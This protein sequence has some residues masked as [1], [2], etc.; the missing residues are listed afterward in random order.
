MKIISLLALLISFTPTS[1]A[2]KQTFDLITFTPPKGWTIEEKQNVIVY[3]NVD[4]KNKTWCQIGVYKS[5]ASKGNIEDDLQS[6]WNEMAVKQ[7][8]IADT[9]QATETQEAEGWKI[10]TGSGKFTFNNQPAAVLLTTFSGYDRCTS[11]I[12]TTNSQSYLETIEKFVGSI[13]LK[14]PEKTGN[15]NILTVQQTSTSNPGFAFSTTNFDDG[16]T[17]T[18]QEDWVEVTKGSMKVLLHYPKEGTIFPA[19]PAPLTNAAWNI[20]V[21]PRY[22]NLK[23]YKT[24]YV[25]DYKRPYFGMGYATEN[26][27]GNSVFIVLFRRGGGWIEVVTT[28]NNSFTREFGFNPETIRWGAISEYMGGWVVNNSQ[29]NTVKADPE[30]FDKL[31]NMVGRNK[32]AVAASDL[33]NT[34]EWKDFFSSNTFYTNYYT[35][36]SAGMSTYSSSKWFVFKAG[37]NYHW[38]LAAANSYGGQIAVAKAKGEGTYKSLNNWQLY[39][40]EMEGKPKTFDVYFSAI[41]GGRVL[42]MNDAQVPGSGI[43]TGYKKSK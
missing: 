30:V 28:D 16:W 14:K 31:E 17:S 18:V 43:F 39:F 21:A 38:E 1:F 15:T 23:N 11:I 7:F 20:I 22:S 19:D 37:N 42:W 29:G 13:D 35:G 40:T 26:K 24:C 34:G 3:T 41:K 25:E 12:A 5:T 32:F 2:Q 27:T 36:A 6:E 9:M 8:N 33:Y 4:K 10:K